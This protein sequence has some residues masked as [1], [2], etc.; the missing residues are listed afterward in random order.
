[1]PLFR[2]RQGHG[3]R[4]L[5][6]RDEVRATLE[7]WLSG[8]RR[9]AWTPR[10][11]TASDGES[12]SQFCGS[13]WLRD[14]EPPIECLGCRRPLQPFVQLDLG[15]VPNELSGTFGD[16]VLQLLY[17]PG[18]TE[19]GEWPA[20]WGEHGWEPF[21]DQVS[22]VR[23]V[24]AD[25]LLPRQVPGVGEDDFAAVR[26]VGW[27]RFDDLPHPE[28]H[29][30]LGMHWEFDRDA[31]SVILSHPGLGL[32]VTTSIDLEEVADAA[33]GEKLSGWPCWIQGAEYPNCTI[34]G[35]PMRL[36]FQVDSE[37]NVPFMFGDLGIG[38]ITQCS[39][40]LDV[41][42]FGWACS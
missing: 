31:G 15:D 16:G 20:C 18:G 25:G 36:V 5:A 32:S 8:V 12:R 39:A 19:D 29:R 14:S 3:E 37:K 27:D 38:H 17:C 33:T 11:S 28:D 35:E 40:H 41:V 26:I 6:D 23:I 21:S 7:P 34:C 30:S 4:L 10:T 13:Q 9:H 22:R 2:R 24:A 42:A 1:M